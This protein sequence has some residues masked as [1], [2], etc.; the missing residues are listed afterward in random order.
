M[1]VLFGVVFV[2]PYAGTFIGLALQLVWYVSDIKTSLCKFLFY[3]DLVKCVLRKG[4]DSNPGY[5]QGYNGFRDR[6][7]RP[8]RHLS[9]GVFC[10]FA[11]QI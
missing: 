7:D 3:R 1:Y 11:M 2:K 5:P 10:A 4:R 9:K 8:L 6:P